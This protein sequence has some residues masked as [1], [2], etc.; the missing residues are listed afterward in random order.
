MDVEVNVTATEQLRAAGKDL[1]KQVPALVELGKWYLKKAKTTS[2][3]ADFTKANALYNA[4]LVRSR[5]IHHKIDEDHIMQQIV[6]TYDEFV[7]TLTNC[8][9]KLDPDEIRNEIDFHKK[10]LAKER[11]SFKERLGEI[12]SLLRKNDVTEDEHQ[13]HISKVTK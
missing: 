8:N 6:E 11:Q 10:F 9:D 2:N 5:S 12:E 3:P 1:S 4:A 7:H 13:V